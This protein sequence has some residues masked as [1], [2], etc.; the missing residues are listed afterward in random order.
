MAFF[1]SK[2]PARLPYPQHFNVELFQ[3]PSL[4]KTLSLVKTYTFA[5]PICESC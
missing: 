3:S 4:G 2:N 1:S 5:G